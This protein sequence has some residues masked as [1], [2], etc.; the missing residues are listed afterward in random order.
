M[1]RGRELARAVE[2][3]ATAQHI[4]CKEPPVG[5]QGGG[6]LLT[7]IFRWP[8]AERSDRTLHRGWESGRRPAHGRKPEGG[9]SAPR[10]TAQM[11]DAAA[12]TTT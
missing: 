5:S 12:E 1:R 3:H 10:A 11:A 9:C 4:P 2:T 7:D 8:R 6:E